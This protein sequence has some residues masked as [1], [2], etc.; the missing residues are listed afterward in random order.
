MLAELA[1][2]HPTIKCQLTVKHM[3]TNL[4]DKD[5]LNMDV[6]RKKGIKLFKLHKL[7]KMR[8]M[9]RSRKRSLHSVVEVSQIQLTR[10]ETLI[11]KILQ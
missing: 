3:R 6:S 7:K 2:S 11:K 9:C 8:K 4:S 10:I 5:L 1:N